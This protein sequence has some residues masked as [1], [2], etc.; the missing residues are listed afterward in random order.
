MENVNIIGHLSPENIDGD[1]LSFDFI[2]PV[3]SELFKNIDDNFLYKEDLSPKQIKFALYLCY[4]SYM[5]KYPYSFCYLEGESFIENI[6]NHNRTTEL[7]SVI[8]NDIGDIEK[9]IFIE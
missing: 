8:K 4:N 6:E 5:E 7:I 1:I 3:H 2:P 9:I